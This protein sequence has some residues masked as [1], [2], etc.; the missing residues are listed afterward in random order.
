[1]QS[2]ILQRTPT[3]LP[4]AA[5]SNLD[6]ALSRA[7]PRAISLLLP[8]STCVY[9]SRYVHASGRPASMASF[10]S[11]VKLQKTSHEANRTFIHAVACHCGRVA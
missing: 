6:L 2:I 7:I 1:M 3:T 5:S 8:T 11:I 10:L 9:I 4:R